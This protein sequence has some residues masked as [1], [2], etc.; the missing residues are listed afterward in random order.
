MSRRAHAANDVAANRRRRRA[1]RERSRRARPSSPRRRTPPAPPSGTSRS[2]T[3]TTRMSSVP[4]IGS[5]YCGACCFAIAVIAA[6][7]SAAVWSFH[8]HACAARLPSNRGSIA[9][10][11]AFAS[12]GSGVEPV[13]STP[14]PI[15]RSREKPGAFAASRE[16]RGDR[17]AER[18]DVVGRILAREVRIRRMRQHAVVAAVILADAGADG[19]AVIARHHDRAA[20]VGS[21]VDTDCVHADWGQVLK[22]SRLLSQG[23]RSSCRDLILTWQNARFQHLTPR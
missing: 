14:M 18:A 10:G 17:M 8:S 4:P 20:G 19:R 21:E 6:A 16:R 3:T 13:V 23:I 11:R 7:S 22:F 1:P 2:S 9:S 12:I 5:R 15:T